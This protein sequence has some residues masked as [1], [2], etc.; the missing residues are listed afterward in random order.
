MEANFFAVKLILRDISIK[1]YGSLAG[2]KTETL[3]R[4]ISVFRREVY[5]HTSGW[6]MFVHLVMHACEYTI[7]VWDLDNDVLSDT[8]RCYTILQ[9]KH[10]GIVIY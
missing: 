2:N 7:C 9:F 1:I 3:K 4:N 5:A 8:V 10:L 6:E